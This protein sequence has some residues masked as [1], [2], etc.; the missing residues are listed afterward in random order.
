MW[1]ES[2]LEYFKERCQHYLKE[3]EENN[4]NFHAREQASKQKI[5]S[6]TLRI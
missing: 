2:V 5:H 6:G 1:K 4:D 3:A